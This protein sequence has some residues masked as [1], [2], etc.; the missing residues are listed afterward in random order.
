MALPR[1][2][3][4]GSSHLVPLEMA[5]QE[6]E[7]GPMWQTRRRR[8]LLAS[9]LPPGT[10]DVQEGRT[11][12]EVLEQYRAMTAS[13]QTWR[14]VHPYPLRRAI[15]LLG[16]EDL[17]TLFQERRDDPGIPIIEQLAADRE[18]V[19][20]ISSR[21][22]SIRGQ[23]LQYIPK[24]YVCTIIPQQAQSDRFNNVVRQINDRIRDSLRSKYLI[25]LHRHLTHH[26]ICEDGI[27][28]NRNG[29]DILTALLQQVQDP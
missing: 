15:V 13:L 8:R 18:I 21:I 19:V 26:H 28:L 22:L 9:D 16:D 6:L 14:E 23:L 1:T 5:P 27:Y 20:T 29:A 12:A 17:R 11:A 3:Y 2:L 7:Y 4:V 10:L 25:H 24:V